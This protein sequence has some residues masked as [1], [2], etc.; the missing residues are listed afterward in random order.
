M[1]DAN[2]R[3]LLGDFAHV[4]GRSVGRVVVNENRFPG[5]A[6]KR[7]RE[8]IEQR[9]HVIAFVKRRYDDGQLDRPPVASRPLGKFT[10]SSCRGIHGVHRSTPVMKSNPGTPIR[11]RRIPSLLDLPCSASDAL[12]GVAAL[13]GAF[14]SWARE[15]DGSLADLKIFEEQR[16]R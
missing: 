8:A 1:D 16:F 4:I 3:V 11:W 9:N 2:P 14:L 5:N 12:R 10:K 7:G 6:V 15:P 13:A